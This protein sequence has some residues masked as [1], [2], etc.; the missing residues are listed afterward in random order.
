MFAK[1]PSLKLDDNPPAVPL[2]TIRSDIMMLYDRWSRTDSGG[3]SKALRSMIGVHEEI[4]LVENFRKILGIQ[5][6]SLCFSEHIKNR[7]MS[8]LKQKM[9]KHQEEAEKALKSL[10]TTMNQTL[11]TKDKFSELG[12]PSAIIHY[13]AGM[14]EGMKNLLI[15]RK[16]SLEKISSVK[17]FSKEFE[18]VQ[19]ILLFV[20]ETDN[21][22][23]HTHAS[24]A[25]GNADLSVPTTFSGV[26]SNGGRNL[27]HNTFSLE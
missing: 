20:S 11:E 2:A 6:L 3:F 21:E 16:T 1:A 19:Y 8:S 24:Q 18:H 25:H 4:E 5:Y 12:V 15:L 17:C 14:Y 13:F 10:E 9:A 23:I 22:Y 27:F 7:C 26:F